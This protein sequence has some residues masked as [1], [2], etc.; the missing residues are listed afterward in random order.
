MK[1]FTV[2][3]YLSQPRGEDYRRI[4]STFA[5][6]RQE[7]VLQLRPAELASAALLS[8]DD[9]E[10]LLSQL[11]QWGN[12]DRAKDHS[13][14]STITDYYRVKWLYQLSSRGEAAERAL[15]LFED[16]LSQPGALQTG[17]LR[18][19]SSYLDALHNLLASEQPDAAKLHNQLNQLDNDFE[20]FTVQAQRFMQFLQN[21]IELH[22]LS[23]EDFIAYKERLIDYLQ[24]FIQELITL[25]SEIGHKLQKLESKGLRELLPAVAKIARRD[26]L[27]TD[28]LILLQREEDSRQGRWQG[29][30]LWFLGASDRPPQAETLRARAREAIPSL[31]LALQSVNERR[32]SGSDR[33]RDWQELA[34]W[35]AECASDAD[36]HRLWRVAFA[37]APARHLRINEETLDLQEKA[38]D[39]PRTSWLASEPM[40]LQPQLRKSGRA[41]RSGAAPKLVDLS[42]ERELLRRQ[43]EQENAEIAEAHR[44]LASGDELTLSDFQNLNPRAFSLLLDLLGRGVAASAFC[45]EEDF[46]LTLNSIDGSLAISLSP[47]LNSSPP[48]RVRTTQGT[49]T[50]PD[51]RIRISAT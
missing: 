11:H 9:T 30:R 39:G 45:K 41:N 7:F 16:S 27:D 34:R 10:A 22:G 32:E 50:G 4:L 24:R 43:A 35:F 33:A 29:L 6:A 8:E 28:D 37:L 18:D 48:A 3:T 17:T 36:A 38:G 23:Q 26:A 31:L 51:Y 2:F 14:A 12:L 49:L 19:I 42:Q 13:E 1:E 21:T 15:T 40:W 47:P 5:K 44:E 46:P 25:S 20:E